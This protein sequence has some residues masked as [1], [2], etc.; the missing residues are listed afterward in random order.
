V[1]CLQCITTSIVFVV[2]DRISSM[3]ATVDLADRIER[4][5][6][7]IHIHT[8]TSLVLA[9]WRVVGPFKSFLV[10]RFLIFVHIWRLSDLRQ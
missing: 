4:I 3:L 10:A 8:H 9:S 6:T 5:V 1:P 7:S 2:R